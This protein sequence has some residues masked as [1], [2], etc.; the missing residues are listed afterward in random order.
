MNEVKLKISS[1]LHF[2]HQKATIFLSVSVIVLLEQLDDCRLNL[3]HTSE[4]VSTS[5]RNDAQLRRTLDE[6]VIGWVIHE[7]YYRCGG[8]LDESRDGKSIFKPHK[9]RKQK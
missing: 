8:D 7:Q 4:T 6:E 1:L 5:P 3:C 2:H 9:E